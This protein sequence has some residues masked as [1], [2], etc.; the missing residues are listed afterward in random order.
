[1]SEVLVRAAQA[2][3]AGHTKPVSTVLVVDFGAQYAQ[4]IARRVREAH[5]YSEI[6]P[7][8]MSVAEILAKRPSAII[9]SGGPS[10][11]YAPGAPTLDPA[12]LAAGRARPRDLLRVPRDGKSTGRARGQDG[13]TG[14]RPH[15][16]DHRPAIGVVRGSA[17]VPRRVDVALRLRAATPPTFTATASSTGATVAA[18]EN[19]ESRLYGV[20]WHPEVIHTEYGQQV[21]ERFL[22]RC[23][24][25][26]ARLVHDQHHRQ[27]HRVHPGRG[28]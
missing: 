23:A 17:R 11:V 7:N 27:L 5:V 25:T 3:S 12:L 26:R 13:A 6:V 9:L 19:T 2:P 8:T 18:F 21:I 28:R 22:Y 4:L 10:S 20:Q 15:H 16:G 24:R 1:M 14:V